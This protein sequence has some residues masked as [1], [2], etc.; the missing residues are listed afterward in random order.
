MKFNFNSIWK[1]IAGGGTGYQAFYERFTS[2]Q[3]AEEVNRNI[4]DMNQKIDSL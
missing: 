2:K 3:K 4:Q 1:Y